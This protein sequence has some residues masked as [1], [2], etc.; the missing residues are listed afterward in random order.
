MDALA[1]YSLT[2]LPTTEVIVKTKRPA[3]RYKKQDCVAN[4]VEYVCSQCRQ[5]VYLSEKDTVQCS[6]CDFRAV[7]KVSK[8][9]VKTFDAV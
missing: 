5:V 9:V 8:G 1:L 7:D 6:F 3:K 2:H 4:T